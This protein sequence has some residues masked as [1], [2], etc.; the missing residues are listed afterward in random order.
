MKEETFENMIGGTRCPG[1]QAEQDARLHENEQTPGLQSNEQAASQLSD[2]QEAILQ[3]D[4][5]AEGQLNDNQTDGL[6]AETQAEEQDDLLPAEIFLREHCEFRY[7]VLADKIE[8]RARK[9]GAWGPWHYLDKMEFNSIVVAA[10]RAMPKERGLKAQMQ[11]SIYSSSTP[12]WDPIAGYLQSLPAWDGRDRVMQLLL[13]IP[14]ITAQQVAWAHVWLLSMVV[15]WLQQDQLHANELVLTLIGAQGCGKSTFLRRLLPEH[16]REY[17]LDHVNLGNKF[18][19]EMALTNNLLVNLDEL[20]Q[21]RPSQQAELKQMVSKVR[22]NGRRIWGSNQSDRSRYASFAATTNNRHPLND[23]TVPSGMQITQE[24][25]DRAEYQMNQAKAA[26]EKATQTYSLELK[27]SI[28]LQEKDAI[29]ESDA[30]AIGTKAVAQVKESI[31]LGSNSV[32]T[33]KD[34]AGSRTGLSGYD[35]LQ[36]DSDNDLEE[37]HQ[38]RR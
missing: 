8:V 9:G 5:Q 16:L 3:G 17:Y 22:V 38:D 7:N 6:H 24:D 10:R 15:H 12:T 11:D 18:D 25:K 21:V 35:P 31:A 4:Q 26:L 14:G 30:I 29:E 2:P 28:R 27:K 19:K 33:A 1:Q 34:R 32:T 20:D 23:P 13:R 37:D 36:Q